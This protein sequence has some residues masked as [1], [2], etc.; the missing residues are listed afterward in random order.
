[1]GGKRREVVLP[2][3]YYSVVEKLS[4][5]SGFK[6]KGNIQHHV[7]VTYVQR[8]GRGEEIL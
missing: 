7:A 6:E 8:R 1:M 4:E 5:T 3:N 2:V